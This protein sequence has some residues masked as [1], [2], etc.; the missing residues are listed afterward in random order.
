MARVVLVADTKLIVAERNPACLAAPAGVNQLLAIGKQGGEGC[1]GVGSAIGQEFRREDEVVR[2]SDRD[3]VTHSV[4]R[5][6]VLLPRRP[7]ASH[8]WRTLGKLD[9]NSYLYGRSS[10]C[11]SMVESSAVPRGADDA[12]RAGQ[13]R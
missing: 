12:R 6:C 10:E 7:T 8:H 9:S 5:S 11:R 2:D 4:H 3:Q 1:A 13:T